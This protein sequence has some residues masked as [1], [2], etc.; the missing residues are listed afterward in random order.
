MDVAHVHETFQESLSKSLGLVV[1]SEIGDKTFF[2]AA[3]LAMR[4]GRSRVR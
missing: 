4:Y 3:L 2:I 1:L